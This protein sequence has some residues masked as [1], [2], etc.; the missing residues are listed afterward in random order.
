MSITCT[1]D[2]PS[3][4]FFAR[5][6]RQSLL[7]NNNSKCYM[8]T[9]VIE[10]L[11]IALMGCREE[12]SNCLLQNVLLERGVG[13]AD[14]QRDIPIQRESKAWRRERNSGVLFAQLHA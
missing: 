12:A 6:E 9:T 8:K 10:L 2:A 11:H 4:E 7:G 13:W 5:A 1:S 3:T 14:V